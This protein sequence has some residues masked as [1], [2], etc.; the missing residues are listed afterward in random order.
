[1]THIP[2]STIED[3]PRFVSVIQEM[4]HSK[5]LPDLK[6]WHASIKD[7]KSKAAR[8]RVAKREAQEAEKAAKELGLWDEFYGSGKKGDRKGKGKANDEDQHQGGEDHSALQA[9]ILAKQKKR[10]GIF[11]NLA[12]KYADVGSGTPKKR[13][14]KAD[15]NSPAKRVRGDPPAINDE[16]FAQ[17]QEKLSKEKLKKK[18]S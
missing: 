13:K 11:D 15:S 14:N 12:A 5:E 9:L 16:E 3:E 6:S 1:M 18:R 10:E 8:K 7:D 2:F 4:I 17:I